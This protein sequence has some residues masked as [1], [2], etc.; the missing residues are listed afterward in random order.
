MSLRLSLDFGNA[1]GGTLEFQVLGSV[2]LRVD[3]AVHPLRQKSTGLL[4]LMINSSN[5]PIPADVLIERLW[6]G[7]PPRTAD[8]ALRVYLAELR[9]ALRQ[10]PERPSRLA[11]TSQGYVL[12]I[13]DGE[14]DSERFVRTTDAVARQNGFPN[15]AAL[16]EMRE[17]EELWRGD[18]FEGFDDIDELVHAR[19]YLRRRR[20]ELHL[21]LCD[22]E[23]AFGNFERTLASASKWLAADP[24]SEAM[25]TKVVLAHYRSGNQV[26]ALRQWRSF[27]DL[28]RDG[29]GL[30]PSEQFLTLENQ[31]LIHDPGLTGQRISPPAVAP[32]E[33]SRYGVAL[34]QREALLREILGLVSRSHA[35]AQVIRIAGGSGMGKTAVLAAIH[36]E[37]AT[38]VMV[39]VRRGERP[40]SAVRDLLHGVNPA[41]ARPLPFAAHLAAETDHLAALAAEVRNALDAHGVRV[42]LID[43]VHELDRDSRAVFRRVIDHGHGSDWIVTDLSSADGPDQLTMALTRH[44]DVVE[45]KL[46]PLNEESV[47]IV[48]ERAGMDEGLALRVSEYTAGVP[49]LVTLAARHLASG[50]D[51]EDLGASSGALVDRLLEPLSSLDR[52]VLEFGCID[53]GATF[54]LDVLAACCGVPLGELVE[55]LERSLAIGILHDRDGP[56]VGFRHRFARDA[57]ASTLTMPLRSSLHSALAHSLIAQAPTEVG[58]IAWHLR[59]CHRP[60]LAG[61]AARW[62]ALEARDASSFGAVLAA[63]D[64]LKSAV[65]LGR[66]AGLSE[67]LLLSWDLERCE[68]LAASGQLERSHVLASECAARARRIGASALFAQAAVSLAGPMIPTGAVRDQC[69][70]LLVEALEWLELD[71]TDERLRV[72]EAA[73]R[74]VIGSSSQAVQR[75]REDIRPLLLTACDQAGQPSR[76]T[77]AQLGMRSLSWHDDASPNDRLRWSTLA[78]RSAAQSAHPALELAAFR[79][80]A[81]DHFETGNTALG[82]LLG[83]YGRSAD[84][85]GADF[86]RWLVARISR[87]G[88]KQT[89]M[90]PRSSRRWPLPDPWPPPLSLKSRTVRI[91]RRIRPIPH[92]R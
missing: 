5:R 35:V 81:A 54:D 87:V 37:S 70:L 14:L 16:L 40:L 9:A 8:S 41:G 90:C 33:R 25:A 48:L 21:A 58:R 22:T 53:R 74:T 89:A 69:E 75:V 83:S 46:D 52:R 56:G 62:T 77:H 92:C 10:A 44:V 51:L 7:R 86:H 26:E 11:T 29:F 1:S 47:G 12:T 28:L 78:L 68:V 31:I 36:A 32:G 15:Y 27:G 84:L 45:F 38:S 72:A 19:N 6:N 59:E 34:L 43:N 63:A 71:S 79:V 64:L 55:S 61:E 66:S 42:V 49:F 67:E 17:A 57:I 30:D 73:L 82:E 39:T 76:R 80:A 4:A 3:G 13:E 23:M 50:H 88:L 24:T 91:W 60:G 85:N 18:A 65:D 2:A 20:S